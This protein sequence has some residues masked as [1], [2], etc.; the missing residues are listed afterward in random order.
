MKQPKPEWHQ[1]YV[2]HCPD[3]NCNGML[4][5]SIYYHAEK[6]D[7]CGKLWLAITKYEEVDELV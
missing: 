7:Q 2:A 4:L 1:S 6:C 3:P 5:Q